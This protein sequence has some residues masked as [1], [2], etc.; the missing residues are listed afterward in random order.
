MPETK[1]R[2]NI[3]LLVTD[4]RAARA[5]GCAGPDQLHGFNARSTT[6][7]WASDFCPRPS[8]IGTSL[9]LLPTIG[10]NMAALVSTTA[11]QLSREPDLFGAGQEPSVVVSETANN[12]SIGGALI[13]LITLGIQGSVT[14][15]ILNGAMTIHNLQPG[16]LLS[17][18][19]PGYCLR[20]H[21]LLSEGM[22]S[23]ADG[24]VGRG[25]AD[26][27]V[28]EDSKGGPAGHHH[29]LQC[30]RLVRANNSF[31]TFGS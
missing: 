23:H 14:E 31:S 19:A 9:G 1:S 18:N 22:S 7:C 26:R 12:A 29:D 15:A 4:Q 25:K 27:P 11:K 5:M 20:H 8:V 13:P 17:Q 21:R 3:V 30:R 24:D 10:A 16:P 28:N 2:P 6:Y